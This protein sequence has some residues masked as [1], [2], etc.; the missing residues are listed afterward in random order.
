[1]GGWK[2][3]LPQ[4]AECGWCPGGGGVVIILPFFSGSKSYSGDGSPFFGTIP[5]LGS[6]GSGG[7]IDYRRIVTG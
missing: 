4:A 2:K 3:T 1:M 5:V 7:R 6:G